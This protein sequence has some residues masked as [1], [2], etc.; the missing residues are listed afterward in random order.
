[1]QDRGYIKWA[2]F[3]SVINDNVVL[4]ELTKK[5]NKVYKPTLSEDQIDFLNEKIF[6]AYTNHLKVNIFIYSNFNILKLSGFINNINL[7][8]KYITFNNNHIYF[9]QILKITNFFEKINEN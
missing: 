2:P 7:S 4:N 5:R 1:M 9:N 3:N 6:E 8:K